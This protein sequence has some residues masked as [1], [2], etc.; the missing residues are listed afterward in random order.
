MAAWA[1]A[2]CS[3][4]KNTFVARNW[5]NLL[6]HYNSYF[7]AREKLTVV[8][9]STWKSI[10]DNY[11]RPLAVLPPP[12]QAS[13]AKAELEEIVKKG[14]IPIQR[15]KNSDWV[16]DSYLIIGKARYYQDDYE[17]ATHTFKYLVS[18]AKDENVKHASLVWLLRTYTD[19]KE[20]SYARQATEAA[21]GKVLNNKN[22]KDFYLAMAHYHTKFREW[23]EVLGY[24]EEAL[25]LMKRD[26]YRARMEFLAGQLR[27]RFNDDS[28]ANAHYTMVTRCRPT[29]ELEFNARVNAAQTQTL[30]DEKGAKSIRKYFRKQLKDEKNLEFKDKI[31]YE[32]A[33]FE[34]KQKEVPKALEFANLSLRSNGKTVGMKGYAYL[35]QGQIYY[36]K[37]KRF[38]RAKIYYDSAVL[39]LDSTE[40]NYKAIVKRQKVLTEF[41]AQYEIIQREDSLRTLV[42]LGEPKLTEK[43]TAMANKKV[44][45]QVAQAKAAEKEARRLEREEAAREANQ[46]GGGGLNPQGPT[47][48]LPDLT[49]QQGVWYFY[50]TAQVSAGK[51]T[52][53]RKWGRRKLE[54]NWRRAKK[55]VEIEEEDTTA[56]A[57]EAKQ[58]VADEVKADAVAADKKENPNKKEDTKPPTEGDAI[59]LLV[60]EYRNGLPT[61][62]EAIAA[63]DKKLQPAL[64]AIGKIYDQ[65]LEEPYNGISSFARLTYNYPEFD[66]DPEALYNLYIIYGHVKQPAKADS[67]KGVLLAKHPG[68]LFA[69]LAED[70]QYLAKSRQQTEAAKTLYRQAYNSYKQGA[71]IEAG[72]AIASIRKDYPENSFKD[73][74]D[75]LGALLTAK[76]IDPTVYKDSLAAVMA[77]Y[78]KSDLQPTLKQ[79]QATADRFGKPPISTIPAMA[80]TAA[81][82]G[83]VVEP[84][85]SGT[86]TA[87]TGPAQWS[88]KKDAGHVYIA[89]LP[90]ESV[91]EL[92][93]KNILS[94]FND[95]FFPQ[96]K[97]TTTTIPFNNEVYFARSSELRTLIVAQKYLEKQ[98]SLDGAFDY[99]EVRI[100]QYII[101]PENFR[102]LMR[103]KDLEGYKRFYKENYEGK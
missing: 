45:A 30:N 49:A 6:A 26:F 79:M 58:K 77:R 89:V 47:A 97:L 53:V 37:L 72:Q 66:K 54:D 64:F 23:P 81:E 51:A 12:G 102:E 22:K 71:Y 39:A 67:V 17:N 27:Q 84:T 1:L 73:R 63:S 3:A 90:V 55:E 42:A 86:E 16:D 41:V 100:K 96:E 43:L 50:N 52:F 19:M 13:S 24:V 5:H 101:T 44:K 65:K 92:D 25:P 8:E 11:N 38:D 60:E 70:P 68:T 82:G 99:M 21:L 62:P 33:R 29:Y 20:Y 32:M 14:S 103:T 98:E 94:D 88:T 87:R 10:Q 61:S 40:E 74:V 35:L 69:K 15:H 59:A 46:G 2:A 18:K 95:L 7:I 75:L 78:P 85:A 4:E 80:A 36:E 83:A 9:L 31:Y 93:G 48:T 57:A 28:T 76:I 91:T 56:I 34:L